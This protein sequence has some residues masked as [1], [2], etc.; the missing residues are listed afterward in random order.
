MLVMVVMDGSVGVS[1]DE[2]VNRF[3]PYPLLALVRSLQWNAVL[4]A[5]QDKAA[6][7][8]ALLLKQDLG[9]GVVGDWCGRGHG[10][11]RG[12]VGGVEMIS[13]NLVCA[14]GQG[15]GVATERLDLL[16]AIPHLD[17]EIP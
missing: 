8:E 9:V 17:P 5:E 11:S 12:L 15:E 3:S 2:A 1:S 13:D 6:V 16:D 4:D 7:V 10:G 14:E